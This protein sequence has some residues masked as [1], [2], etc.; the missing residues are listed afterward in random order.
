MERTE[1]F[2]GVN[3]SLKSFSVALTVLVFTLML[4][5]AALSAG[6]ATGVAGLRELLKGS[7]TLL[8]KLEM[9]APK[10]SSVRAARAHAELAKAMDMYKPL[11]KK[12]TLASQR[13]AA[14]EM[15]LGKEIRK[16]T[17]L[18]KIEKELYGTTD[19]PKAFAAEREVKEMFRAAQALKGKTGAVD[20]LEQQFALIEQ[21]YA[22]AMKTATKE[23]RRQLVGQRV[24]DKRQ[25]LVDFEASLWSGLSA[26][27][28]REFRQKIVKKTGE[29]GAT[30]SLGGIGV[31]TAMQQQL[32]QPDRRVTTGNS[33]KFI[34][35]PYPES[36]TG[37]DHKQNSSDMAQ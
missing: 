7:P 12:I 27:S 9:L 37:K 15:A 2:L 16:A 10:I 28:Q 20:D 31:A 6:Y 11:K 1:V 35:F 23:G 3:M 25:T 17:T 36:P 5:Q 34:W 30:L 24:M 22:A 32:G 21:K 29:V 26:K 14:H 13:P 4:P 8:N 19:L 18:W 33:D